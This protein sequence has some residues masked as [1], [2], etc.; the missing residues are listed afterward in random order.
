MLN[1]LKN[2][3]HNVISGKSQVRYG[4]TIQS[5]ADY[6]SDSTQSST[7]AQDPKQV[8]E[9]EAKSLE[10]LISEKNLWIKDIDFSQYVSERVEGATLDKPSAMM[11]FSLSVSELG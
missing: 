5:V 2:E 11:A 4:A 6:L 7:K 10:F 3:L 8:K 9:Q 1:H